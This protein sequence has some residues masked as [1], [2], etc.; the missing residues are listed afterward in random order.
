MMLAQLSQH[1]FTALFRDHRC[2]DIGGD[3]ILA[4]HSGTKVILD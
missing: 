1:H 3:V 2:G 4:K